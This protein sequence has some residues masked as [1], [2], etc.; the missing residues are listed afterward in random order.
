MA[1]LLF[2]GFVDLEEWKQDSARPT[3]IGNKIEIVRSRSRAEHE[4]EHEAHSVTESHAVG[5]AIGTMTSTGVST[6]DFSASGDSVGLVMQAPAQLF[7]PSAPGA[8]PVSVPLTQSTGDSRSSG[9]SEM[10]STSTGNSHTTIEMHGRAETVGHGRSRG[11]SVTEG[12][13]E[14]YVTQYETLPTQMFSLQEQLHRL[15][16][17]IQNLAHREFFVKINNQRPVRTRTRDLEPTFKS[18]YA[19]RVLMPIFHQKVVA[20]SG[21]LFPVA[22]VDAQIAARLAALTPAPKPQPDTRPEPLP[23]VDAPEQFAR[24]FWS[25]RRPPGPDDDPPKP[26]PTKPKGRRPVG[27]FDQRHDR[28]RVVPGGKDGDNEK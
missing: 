4:A 16:G 14:T 19:R 26:K 2:R 21:F 27:S 22:E 23:V 25:K 24:D 11:T 20:R 17:E 8:Q 18:A 7:S 9:S 1:N 6:G 12:E 28:F 5:E 15:A 13:S 3:A 10:S